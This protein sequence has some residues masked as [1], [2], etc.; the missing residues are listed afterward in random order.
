M[1]LPEIPKSWLITILMI[2]LM[3]L[4]AYDIDT[5]VTAGMSGIIFYL[6]GRHVYQNDRKTYKDK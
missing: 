2:G 3:I 5:F 1:Q 4:R 6:F